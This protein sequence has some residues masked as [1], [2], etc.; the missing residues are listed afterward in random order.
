MYTTKLTLTVT[1]PG[2]PDEDAA[3]LA[4]ADRL[5]REARPAPGGAARGLWQRGD[6]CG[7]CWTVDQLSQPQ[8]E[9]NR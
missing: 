8:R 7:F 3:R 2:S 6:G 5:E 9:E 4:L 1:L